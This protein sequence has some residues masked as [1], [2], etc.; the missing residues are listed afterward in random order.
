[1]RLGTVVLT[2]VLWSASASAQS[3]CGWMHDTD[4][5]GTSAF[6]T[7]V[8]SVKSGTG[9]S[10]FQCPT[11]IPLTVTLDDNLPNHTTTYH[12]HF[13][14]CRSLCNISTSTRFFIRANRSPRTGSSTLFF[15]PAACP[16]PTECTT[17]AN[18]YV[19]SVVMTGFKS[20][21]T[22]SAGT[23]TQN[24]AGTR[25]HH[26]YDL[27][28]G[29]GIPGVPQGF[30]SSRSF[31]SGYQTIW[32]NA[33][34]VLNSSATTNLQT[35]NSVTMPVTIDIVMAR[36]TAGS[37][38][39]QDFT[40]SV[41]ADTLGGGGSMGL[42]PVARSGGHWTSSPPAPGWVDCTDQL[43][44]CTPPG[45]AALCPVG[46][47]CPLGFTSFQPNN[48]G[49][50]FG[51][52]GTS[53][54]Y[55]I[56]APTETP[57]ITPTASLTPTA[58]QTPSRTFTNTPTPANT[59]TVT[60][61]P[62]PT[63]TPTE[64]PTPTVRLAGIL[65][66]ESPVDPTQVHALEP[67]ANPAVNHRQSGGF[68]VDTPGILR[69]VQTPA[70]DP[71]DY[72]SKSW[73]EI[74]PPNGGRSFGFLDFNAPALKSGIHVRSRFV[75][76]PFN[77]PR[78][79][80]GLVHANTCVGGTR[81]QLNC[82]TLG[83]VPECPGGV[84]SAA[85]DTFQLGCFA[86]L[87]GA[88]SFVGQ[89]QSSILKV[90]YRDT[91]PECS[92]A[93]NNNADCSGPQQGNFA[94]PVAGNCDESLCDD[95]P[96]TQSPI[97][98][99]GDTHEFMLG[100]THVAGTGSVQCEL[101]MDGIQVGGGSDRPGGQCAGPFNQFGV[102]YACRTDADCGI[103]SGGANNG[104]VCR[105]GADTVP[106]G[107]LNCFYTPPSANPNN[108]KNCSTPCT[109]GCTEC[110]SGGQCLG[111]QQDCPGGSCGSGACSLLNT[112]LP[113]QAR[114]GSDD[115][116]AEVVNFHGYYDSVVV[117]D[118]GFYIIKRNR[119]NSIYPIGDTS[120]TEWTPF[121]ASPTT[122]FDK[123][124]DLITG[125]PN[126]NTDYVSATTAAVIDTF[127]LQ[128]APTPAVN[129]VC[130]GGTHQGVPCTLNAQCPGSTCT[131]SEV[132][133]AM[134][135]YL[136]AEVTPGP[137]PSLH[138]LQLGFS[139]VGGSSIIVSTAAN[140]GGWASGTYFTGL[141]TIFPESPTGG[142]WNFSPFT[143]RLR[144]TQTIGSADEVR[145]TAVGAVQLVER[146]LPSR[147]I[148][149]TDIDGD[150]QIRLC[151]AGHSVYDDS[152]YASQV[153]VNVPQL[154][155]LLQC[156]R[157]GLA[158]L[159]ADHYAKRLVYG[160]PRVDVSC[161]GGVN[162]GGQ[163]VT[164]GDCP[165]GACSANGNLGW[166][167]KIIKG[168]QGHCDYVAFDFAV[169]D[170]QTQPN[171]LRQGFCHDNDGPESGNDCWCPT[172][173]N[174]TFAG[175]AFCIAGPNFGMPCGSC[176]GGSNPGVACTQ[177]SDCIGGQCIG[178]STLC[179]PYTGPTLDQT[180]DFQTCRGGANFEHYCTQD[181]DCPGS[182][183][184]T[185]PFRT[186]EIPT[187][188]NAQGCRTGVCAQSKNMS[189]EF[190]LLNHI[191]DQFDRFSTQ[192]VCV[193]G[194]TQGQA[195]TVN[196]DCNSNVCRVFPFKTILMKPS[197]TVG[198]PAAPYFPSWLRNDQEMER[199]RYMYDAQV[200]ARAYNT[201]DL[202][203]QYGE[204]CGGTNGMCF[205]DQVHPSEP[206][207]CCT[208]QACTASNGV[209]CPFTQSCASG[210][211]S[212]I[213]GSCGQY[214]N[215]GACAQAHAL[216]GCLVQVCIGG[217]NPGASCG[218][219][220]DCTGGGACGPTTDTAT[221]THLR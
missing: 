178:D 58:S 10:P 103:C 11:S 140:I 184:V 99:T 38:G 137:T 49:F 14:I 179:P 175:Q 68:L 77:V 42:A 57:T 110:P 26:T 39:G 171:F 163:C 131:G 31:N 90:Y 67:V 189:I 151:I 210:A 97:L 123:V 181:A 2:A 91:N 219:N 50:S 174:L 48:G 135:A 182:T 204:D 5:G 166:T 33:P 1:M 209:Q 79:V 81:D 45:G 143:D 3:I 84:C 196:G 193:G 213:F 198:A 75:T 22:V 125:L 20:N 161:S 139:N 106:T 82:E 54:C 71:I 207:Q 218:T 113:T 62:T 127:Q 8:N 186:C 214:P 124:A 146:P 155:S 187:C 46:V 201:I 160:Q 221:C 40:F 32:F 132:A 177:E 118:N 65:D 126:G 102:Q 203:K 78:R 15:D 122:Q 73:L 191:F 85:N 158:S 167:C 27:V 117:Q 156:T 217:S 112:R 111:A 108:G 56:F 130:A 150:G 25:I 107:C 95:N 200:A 119:L 23:V 88:T 47:A 17:V 153:A 6:V 104:K 216:E 133:R 148:T 7:P 96:F 12:L 66:F 202:F 168:T 105:P 144:L 157:G 43:H 4:T 87:S 120:S 147:G 18:Q 44:C 80:L 36:N 30:V 61:T 173:T 176:T 115:N 136:N 128:A 199:V 93:R 51:N 29:A 109:T 159:D 206:A 63:P 169:N 16:S 21:G 24:G 212:S 170:I 76:P 89:A 121:P 92:A 60:N 74:I 152:Y 194:T 145:V 83:S 185:T 188:I 149:L 220:A 59:A 205:R 195:C 19:S 141:Q 114:F 165:G 53:S 211:C 100:E 134:A 37:M 215:T 154:D 72:Q 116:A 13:G 172:L 142:P 164:N 192:T 52:D 129:I 9:S 183:C 86:I 101:W 41:W 28:T 64:T 162:A 69:T 138:T 180:F 55:D 197:M 94:C 190:D 70:P 34:V 35:D 208:T 98:T